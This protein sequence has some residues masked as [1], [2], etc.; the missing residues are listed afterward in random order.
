MTNLKHKLALKNVVGF[1]H[2]RAVVIL[3]LIFS[4]PVACDAVRVK[5]TSPPSS[6]IT[7]QSNQI[8]SLWDQQLKEL[9]HL[10]KNYPKD[11]LDVLLTILEKFSA[12]EIRSESERILETPLAYAKM[13]EYEQT[14]MQALVVRALNENNR[15]SL[16]DLLARKA[17]R[18]IAANPIELYLTI[19]D[20]DNILFLF[21]SYQQTSASDNKQV[22]MEALNGSFKDQRK[23]L[24][25]DEEFL[26]VSKEWYLKNRSKLRVNPYYYPRE[27][28]PST[29]HLFVVNHPV[30]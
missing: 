4:C 25:S 26:K 16:V 21:E 15:S 30:P 14:F 7:E 11:R 6:N 23:L 2:F 1:T 22:L 5:T 17:P 24:K 10:T 9:D 18:S 28:S 13:S 29:W 3:A 8:R 19:K 27:S 12:Q 20:A